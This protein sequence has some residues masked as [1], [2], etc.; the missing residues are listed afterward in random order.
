MS[1]ASQIEDA[2]TY[3]ESAYAMIEQRGGTIPQRKN[4]QNLATAIATIPSSGGTQ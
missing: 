1:I 4:L 3:I 2:T